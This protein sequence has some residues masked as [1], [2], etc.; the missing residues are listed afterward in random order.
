MKEFKVLDV[1]SIYINPD[2]PIDEATSTFTGVTQDLMGKEGVSFSA[3]MD[4][5]STKI[6]DNFVNKF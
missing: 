2:Q 4:K 1:A 5:V 6:S 3:A